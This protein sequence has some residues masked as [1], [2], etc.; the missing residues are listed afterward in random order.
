MRDFKKGFLQQA[1]RYGGRVKASN[2]LLTELMR[3]PGGRM[4]PPYKTLLKNRSAFMVSLYN[5]GK[6]KKTDLFLRRGGY[7]WDLFFDLLKRIYIIGNIVPNRHTK[8]FGY[9][10]RNL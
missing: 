8:T 2:R 1:L 3:L 6:H 4:R 9:F 5:K 10:I 7:V